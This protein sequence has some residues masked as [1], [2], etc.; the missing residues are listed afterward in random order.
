MNS[1]DFSLVAGALGRTVLPPVSEHN[2]SPH[3]LLDVEE[4]YCFT[5]V[6]ELFVAAYAS[7]I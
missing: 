7:S 1:F 6:P 4:P 2:L 5:A 3:T